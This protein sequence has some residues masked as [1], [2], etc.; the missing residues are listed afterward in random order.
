MIVLLCMAILQD[1]GIDKVMNFPYPTPPDKEALVVAEKL[2]LGLGALE[3]LEGKQGPSRPST[4]PSTSKQ[5]QERHTRLTP[6]GKAMASFPVAPR[7]G[8]MLALGHQHNLLQYV[9]T[10]V[11]A[12]SVQ[13]VFSD[14]EPPSGQDKDAVNLVGDWHRS[15]KVLLY[16]Y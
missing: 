4:R 8:K 16:A 12:L 5:G 10:I 2:L 14:L 1:I 11:A 13:E 9:V 6:L 15:V 3:L 7:Y